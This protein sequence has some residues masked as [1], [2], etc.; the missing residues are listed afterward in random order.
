MQMMMMQSPPPPPPAPA[1]AP[2][3]AAEYHPKYR[4]VV[5][6]SSMDSAVESDS[7]ESHPK[8][9][10]RRRS[11]RRRKLIVKVA[12]AEPPR[13]PQDAEQQQVSSVS[14]TFSTED[15]ALSLMMLS[16]DKWKVKNEDRSN[17]EEEEEDE[18]E[19]EMEE[20]DD[21]VFRARSTPR[22]SS[23]GKYK[24]ETC[25]KVFQSYQALGGHRASH[26]RVRH[27]VFE[28]DDDDVDGGDDSEE[29]EEEE[30]N[31]NGGNGEGYNGTSAVVEHPPPRSFECPFCFKLFDSGQA[32]GG[33]KKV[34]YYNNISYYNSSNNNN[35]MNNFPAAANSNN[36]NNAR[37]SSS[38]ANFEDNLV[39]DLN[40]PPAPEEEF[41]FSTV[42]D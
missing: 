32:L 31:G 30:G 40:F 2:A 22:T 17:E 8:N 3:P 4:E 15:C 25:K 18:M 39:I 9:P 16:R 20:E 1:P 24:C 14:D 6:P 42:S 27:Q 36:N 19:Q 13:T 37:A 29:E 41:E 35:N 10:T 5:A 26:K 33:H 23:Q 34:H 7:T 21:V 12:L 28:D 11:K 38:S